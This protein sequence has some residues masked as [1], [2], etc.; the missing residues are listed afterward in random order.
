MKAAR[1]MVGGFCLS[2]YGMVALVAL[3]LAG[4]P[5]QWLGAILPAL[6]L[7]CFLAALVLGITQ[8]VWLWNRRHFPGEEGVPAFLLKLGMTGRLCLLPL[9]IGE[10]VVCGLLLRAFFAQE[11][12]W[13]LLIAVVLL[14]AGWTALAV[15]SGWCM[16]GLTQLQKLGR[17]TEGGWLAHAVAV[18]VPVAGALDALWLYRRYGAGT[19]A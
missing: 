3:L 10:L 5:P 8:A 12:A 18:L 9:E 14:G 15:L 19:K 7:L 17:I 11:S 4:S 13:P 1:Y 2:L 16:M 6:I